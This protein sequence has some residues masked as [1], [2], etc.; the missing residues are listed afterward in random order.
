MQ[1]F[2]IKGQIPLRGEVS[3]SGAKN[4]ALPIMAAAVMTDEP[5]TLENVPF[6][7]DTKNLV[8]ILRQMN[9][10]VE[11]LDRHTLRLDASGLRNGTVDSDEVRKMRA[12]Y[13]LLGALLG[14]FRE[15]TVAMPGGCNF[16]SRPIDQH[17]K[18]FEALGAEVDAGEMVVMKADR[19]VGRKI[20]FDMVSVGATVNAMLA[21]V[22]AEGT[23][24]I[25]NAAK[26]PH[27]VDTAS[28]LNSMGADI[29]GA[30]T[31]IIR[32]Q[33][34]EKLRGS[35]YCIIPDQ[36][37]AGTY[38]VAA[39]ATRGTV[40]VNNVIPQH[41]DCISAKL[42]EMGVIVENGESSVRV[43]AENASFK[44]IMVMTQ[45]YPGFPTDMQPQ[46]TA[47]LSMT[48]GTNVVNETVYDDRFR[49]IPELVKMGAQINVS[50]RMAFV[51]GVRALHG[52]RVTAMDLRAG[53][54]MVIAGLAAEG[55]TLVDNIALI[56]RGYEKLAE[57]L[58]RLG[59]SIERA[60]IEA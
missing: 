45:V 22:L 52:A 56:D 53:A 14:R 16:G 6:I 30:G 12:S 8:T 42:R 19:L 60:E 51:E 59:A 41:L 13:Y 35:E 11:Y 26:E 33:G 5:V 32:I 10:K 25:E 50:G 31:D 9:V 15:A 57:K 20:F 40:T 23:T 1:I 55:E 47:L 54:A 18:A 49:Y 24:I 58:V 27:I 48:P 44:P 43:V 36:I 7:A 17:I 29:K 46:I 34:V 4:A 21:A 39:A 37:E 3:V 28:F 2:K 38:M